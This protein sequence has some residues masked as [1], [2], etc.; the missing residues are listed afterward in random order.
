MAK[1][2]YRRFHIK[3]GPASL[4]ERIRFKFDAPRTLKLHGEHFRSRASERFIPVHEIESFDPR[5]W[6]LVLAE[7]RADTGKFVKS[8]WRKQIESHT[9]WIVIAFN[10]TVQTAYTSDDNSQ[11]FGPDVITSGTM[12]EFVDKVNRELMEAETPL[13]T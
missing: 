1:L 11:K 10:D 13:P 3:T 8:V 5:E 2:E 12:F 4:F 6:D 9:W 7:V